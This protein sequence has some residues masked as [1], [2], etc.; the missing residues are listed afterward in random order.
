MQKR[1]IASV[2]GLLL[3][4][5]LCAPVAASAAEAPGET[6]PGGLSVAS[7]GEGQTR[8]GGGL[9]PEGEGQVRYT[10]HPEG[11]AWNHGT[12]GR[13]TSDYHHPSRTHGSSVKNGR[14]ELSRSPNVR[15]GAWARSSIAKTTAGNS[16]YWRIS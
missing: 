15:G 14:G 7:S 4:G 16:A 6:S 11:G 2:S 13:V 1:I 3:V 8:G 9:L 10:S 5:A 12:V